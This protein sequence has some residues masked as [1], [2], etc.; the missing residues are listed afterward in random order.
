MNQG[1]MTPVLVEAGK[2]INA[3]VG[4]NN[5]GKFENENHE[6]RLNELQ[7]RFDELRD[8]L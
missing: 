7:E 2:S 5:M 8:L 6:Q 4:G 3:V 1:E